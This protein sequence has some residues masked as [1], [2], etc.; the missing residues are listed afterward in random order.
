MNKTDLHEARTNPD[1][2][3]YLEK[4]RTDA[5]DTKDIAA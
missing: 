5:I 1:F 2:L 4:T 3:K